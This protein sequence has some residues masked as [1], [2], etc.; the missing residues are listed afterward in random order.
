MPFLTEKS[1]AIREKRW[2]FADCARGGLHLRCGCLGL[3]PG[4]LLLRNCCLPLRGGFLQ[5]AFGRCGLLRLAA[6]AEGA[7]YYLRYPNSKRLSI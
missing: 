2:L 1:T 4:Y 3:L 6:L 5:R 7:K